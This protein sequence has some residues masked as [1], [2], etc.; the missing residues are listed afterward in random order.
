MNSFLLN[1]KMRSSTG[2]WARMM[3]GLSFAVLLLISSAVKAAPMSGTYT[4]NPSGGNYTTFAAAVSA[5]TTNGVSG[6]VTFNVAAT[7]FNE[8]VTIP[9]ISG[10]SA[11]NTITFQGQGRG[12]SIISN[13][14]SVVYFSSCKYITF[15]GFSITNTGSTYAV[16]AYFSTNCSVVNC[17][18]KASSSCCV[19]CIYD[20][21]NLNYS[22]INNHI[23]GG[24]YC[25]YIYSSPSSTTYANSLY[26]NNTIVGFA[27]YGFMNYYTNNNQYIGNTIDSSA[28]GYGYGVYAFYESGA[29][30]NSNKIIA[31]LYYPM[32]MYYPN[33]YSTSTTFKI[34]NNFFSNYQYYLYL[35]CYYSSNML[36]AHNTVYGGTNYYAMYMYNYYSGSNINIVSNIFYGGGGNP[37][38]YYYTYGTTL[39]APFGM[40]DGN[41]YINPSGG[42]PV[43][44]NNTYATLA[45]YQAAVAG[46]KYTSPYNGTKAAFEGYS[47]TTM[48]TFIN[49]PRD[50]HVNQT[51]VAPTGVYAGIDVDIDGDARCKLFPTAGADEDNFGKSKPIVKFFLPSNIYPGSPTFIY[52]TAKAGEPKAHQWYLNGVKVSDSVVLKTS[53]F[54]TGSNTLKLVTQTC[55][56]NDSFQ[57]T[58]TVAAPTAVP[59][60]DF[61]A[62]KNTI[63]SGQVVSFQD[64]STNGPTKWQWTISPDSTY[65]NG[66]KVPTVKYVFGSPN[67]QN[68]QIQFNFGGKYKVCLTA[69][70]GVGKGATLCKTNYINVIPSVNLA[71]GTQ[72]TKFSNGY[73]YDNGGPNNNYTSDAS[74]GYK[75]SIVIDPCADSVFLTFSMMD[76]YCGYDFVRVYSGRDNTGK[77]LWNSTCNQTGYSGYGPGYTGGKAWS[78]TYACLP[79]VTKPDTFKAKNAMFVQMVP[80]IASS[81]AGF[82]AYWWSTPKAS[83]KPKASFVSSNAHDSVCVNASLNYTNTTK[84]D[85]NDVATFLWDL[86]GDITT[87]ECAGACTNASYPYFL[88]G[89]VNV[90]LIATNCGGSDT[91]THTVTVYNPK[92]P[93]AAFSADNLTPTTND[94]VFFTSQV[95]QCVDDYKW[96]ITPSAGTTG[97]AVFVN[98][99]SAQSPNPQVNFTGTGYYDVKLYVDN[100]SGS[101]KD[102]LTKLKYINARNAYCIPS[103]AT[104]NAGMGISH[105]VFNTIDNKMTQAATEY[106]NFTVNPSLSTSIAIGATYTLTVSRDPS[107]IFNSLTRTAYIDWNGNGVFEASEAYLLDSNSYA[108]DVSKK[109][110]VPKNATVGAT[111]IRLAVNYGVYTNKPCGQNQFGEYQDYRV[112]IT[113]YNILPV[114][115]LKG[116]N[117]VKDTIYLEQGNIFTEPGYTA[118]SFLYGNITKNVIRTS[119]R[120]G[121]SNPSD[122]FNN[123]VP[124]TYI[125]SYNVTDSAGNK[126]ITQYRYV[127][128]TKDKTPP[129]LIVAGP[130]TT[131]IEVTKAPIHPVP[132]P[133]VISADDLVDGPLAGSV[134]IDSGKVQTNIVGTYVVSYT[135]SDLSGNT[136]VV[137]RVV[138]VIDTIAPVM[139]LI[140]KDPTIV[141][142]ND[143]Y[144]EQG[145]TVSDNYYTAGQLNSRVIITSNVDV[146]KVG[147]YTVTYDLTDLSGNHA[148]T[149]TR[150][151]KVVDTIAPVITLNGAQLDSVDVFHAYKDLGVSV[152]DN[153][154]KTSDVTITVTGTFYAKFP[155]GKNPN[156]LGSY[157]IIYTAT[158]KSGNSSSVTRTVLVKDHE[159]PVIKLKGDVALSV[160]RWFNYVDAGYTV[161]ENYDPISSVKITQEGTF[162]TNGGTT[163]WG[164]L[165]LRYR[166]TDLSGNSSV[167][168][169][170][171]I[172]VKPETDFTCVSGVKEGLGLDKY[173]KVFPNPNSG[174]FTISSTLSTQE[175]VRISVTNTLGQEIAVIHNGILDVNS[176]QVDLSSQPAGVYLLNIVTS[177]QTLTKRIEIAK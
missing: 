142:V 31:A 45:A 125:F 162:V 96:T 149:L 46:Y 44:L 172:E 109:I 134:L 48:P 30:Y 107:Q 60:T 18:I 76:L 168:E 78:C 128:V 117:G 140:G 73:L 138:K 122:S 38:V 49:P 108:A 33:Y 169:W 59:G 135:V 7:T 116:H 24:Y 155:G 20:Y 97:K 148:A 55:G 118:T 51:K 159:A 136:A 93:K 81:S 102:S 131:Y 88:A 12:K 82:E 174:I 105:V 11:T 95:V 63:R 146:T 72:T 26:K 127:T 171:Y 145:V 10:A 139:T 40:M 170:R 175:K 115:T 50:L 86:D 173:I 144:T 84:I 89:P 130:D 74:N 147:T 94:V 98:G 3:C 111:V 39:P 100:A 129:A 153:Y 70:N 42:S 22:M 8:A 16:Y 15:N 124:A 61:I 75:E 14:S 64:L 47:S 113:P 25:I 23:S 152:S 62:N 158:D 101:Q 1:K 120:A 29:N 114:I 65:S 99:S 21:Y 66:T 166:A 53:A 151:V 77:P 176:F 52:Q 79:N 106:S 154:D 71:S 32:L 161:T 121:S 126:A 104:L 164:L 157:T 156:V 133:K 36:V 9:N 58:F 27:Y 123:V 4:I 132:V 103:V 119:R 177:N 5:L 43:Y 19:Y 141:E 150:T 110:T 83:T 17:D 57:Q 80:Y 41:A 6:A 112:Y 167:S 68:P 28:N 37:T 163:M 35:Y 56:G 13:T 92:A 160:C 143:V 69:S 137:Y 165:T 67:Y 85:P 87:F 54:V 2:G 34:V 90:T 91:S